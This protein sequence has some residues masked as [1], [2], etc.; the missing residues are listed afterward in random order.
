MTTTTPTPLFVNG[1]MAFYTK[2][3]AQADDTN[4]FALGNILS[5]LE[6]ESRDLANSIINNPR[7]IETPD[8][9]LMLGPLFVK[10][11]QWID[12]RA[13]IANGDD[14]EFTMDGAT[15]KVK[16]QTDLHNGSVFYESNFKGSPFKVSGKMFV[17]TIDKGQ[18]LI[19]L[20]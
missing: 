20:E 15:V 3:G 8:G 17:T 11:I 9:S 16:A 14:L 7:V 10:T 2:V 13:D 5:I 18:L 4:L 19:C 12:N 6:F 1:G